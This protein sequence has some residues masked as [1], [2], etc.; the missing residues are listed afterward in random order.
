MPVEY[1]SGI[2]VTQ[3]HN[4][5]TTV[6][7]FC[8]LF[9]P[10]GSP[11]II[12]LPYI[13]KSPHALGTI[14]GGY[15][16][17]CPFANQGT[18]FASGPEGAGFSSSSGDIRL[19][20]DGIWCRFDDPR[21]L[22]PDAGAPDLSAYVM[23]RRFY[24]EEGIIRLGE[25]AAHSSS[26][27]EIDLGWDDAPQPNGRLFI[28]QTPSGIGW[29]ARFEW[30]QW[31]GSSVEKFIFDQSDQGGLE[32]NDATFDQSDAYPAY[33]YYYIKR[34]HDGATTGTFDGGVHH[35]DDP[36]G[37]GQDFVQRTFSYA[38]H[39][40]ANA[41]QF[42]TSNI[43]DQP[44]SWDVLWW[45]ALGSHTQHVPDIAPQ[46]WVNP[47]VYDVRI[48][49]S[50][51][52]ILATLVDA[53]QDDVYW[54]LPAGVQLFGFNGSKVEVRL[55]ASNSILTGNLNSLFTGD[56]HELPIGGGPVMIPG[57]GPQGRYLYTQMRF[58]PET[59][60]ASGMGIYT[61]AFQLAGPDLVAMSVQ[62][63]TSRWSGVLP[64]VSVFEL[65]DEPN[66]SEG[67][68]P[69]TPVFMAEDETRYLTGRQKMTAPYTVTTGLAT[70][71]RQLWRLT[72]VMTDAEHTA[73]DTFLEARRVG[74]GPFD[75]E[76]PEGGTAVGVLAD[77]DWEFTFD[78]VNTWSGTIRV[79]E[80]F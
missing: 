37:I 38:P 6:A 41:P 69:V 55:H 21:L 7:D 46:K 63:Q 61:S 79:E 57:A 33:C 29:Q 70:R 78:G 5:A 25:A 45:R 30:H 73:V 74:E 15:A 35:A 67:S 4:G 24:W 47:K 50:T 40:S 52:D 18:F 60:D 2:G 17:D 44:R 22:A 64:E 9:A 62:W 3:F 42:C 13:E 66:V 14:T 10:T 1:L 8:R 53:G 11:F 54:N 68:L 32:D 26:P 49:Q 39:D 56:W 58:S 72:L 27:D 59:Q 23:G 31:N 80:V 51:G 65:N 34:V 19:R 48:G 28:E 16:M 12:V 76:K 43:S 75:F 20:Q 77:D 71:H 36:V